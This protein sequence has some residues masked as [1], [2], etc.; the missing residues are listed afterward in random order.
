[1]T[2]KRTGSAVSFL[3]G[4]F[5]KTRFNYD[6]WLILNYNVVC[7]YARY[8]AVDG[9]EEIL[10]RPCE[11]RRQELLAKNLPNYLASHD[12]ATMCQPD[13]WY[14]RVQRNETHEYCVDKYGIP[15]EGYGQLLFEEGMDS[16]ATR[17][18][19]SKS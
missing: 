17:I 5:W 15:I 2:C 18:N 3:L 9:S 10:R 19:C 16:N 11:E 6:L 7:F 8:I 14:D 1:M 12:L 13:G 4:F